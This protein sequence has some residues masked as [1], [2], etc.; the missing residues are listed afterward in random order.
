MTALSL[1]GEKPI[2]SLREKNVLIELQDF[3]AVGV[4]EMPRFGLGVEVF[5]ET[6]RE[7]FLEIPV[8]IEDPRRLA[9]GAD[10]LAV[11]VVIANLEAAVA[12]QLLHSPSGL[13]SLDR[14]YCYGR[15]LCF[16]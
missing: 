10:L 14:L 13:V 4:R 12:V 1:T 16:P 7:A 8:V 5:N 15:G 9:V 6:T 11:A 3:L 2:T